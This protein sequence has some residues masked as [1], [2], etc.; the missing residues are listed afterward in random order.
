M[1]ATVQRHISLGNKAGRLAQVLRN[2]V[3]LYLLDRRNLLQ[4]ILLHR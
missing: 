2:V 3:I 4:F 1:D